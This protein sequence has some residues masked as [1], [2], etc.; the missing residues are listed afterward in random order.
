MWQLETIR[1]GKMFP[2]FAESAKNALYPLL[3]TMQNPVYRDDDKASDLMRLSRQATV[4]GIIASLFGLLLPLS[5]AAAARNDYTTCA[6]ELMEVGIPDETIALACGAALR[7]DELSECVLDINKKTEIAAAEALSTCR[8]VRRPEELATCVVDIRLETEASQVPEVL[9]HCRRSL[10][11][12]AFS[13]CVVGLNLNISIAPE[14]AMA[15]CIDG[16]D[17]PRD[18]YPLSVSPIEPAEELPV[19]SETLQPPA[20]QSAPPPDGFLFSE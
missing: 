13:R 6:D 8:R 12:V 2:L 1:D 18:F 4:T 17:R 19:P 20:E 9:D 14:E 10:L 7:P 3:T 16:R 15:A 5:P 11:P